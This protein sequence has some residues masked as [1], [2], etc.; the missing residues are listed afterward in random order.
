MQNTLST[1][2]M[3]KKTMITTGFKKDSFKME[4]LEFLI[5]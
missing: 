1:S 2:P 3:L 4:N 5:G